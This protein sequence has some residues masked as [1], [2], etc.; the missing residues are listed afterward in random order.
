M[1]TEIKGS[2]LKKRPR[3]KMAQVRRGGELFLEKNLLLRKAKIWNCQGRSR[4]NHKR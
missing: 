3:E 4:R 2:F 1:V